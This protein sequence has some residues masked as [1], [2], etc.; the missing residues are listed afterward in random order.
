[1]GLLIVAGAVLLFVRFNPGKSSQPVDLEALV[2]KIDAG[3]ITK[4][5]LSRDEVI[6]VDTRGQELRV[7][8][9]NLSRRP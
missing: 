4:V 7:K 9:T 6:A 2:R 3:E 8:L 1:L 5:T